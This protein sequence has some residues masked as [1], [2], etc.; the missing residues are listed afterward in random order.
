MSSSEKH[1]EDIAEI[2]Q[3][4]ERS[5]RF[6]SLSGWSGVSAGVFAL[7][8]VF[9]VPLMIRSTS[10]QMLEITLVAGAL[11]VLFLALASAL[12]FSFR[13]ARKQGTKLWSPVTRS[14]LVNMAIPLLTGGIYSAI[15]L[16]QDQGHLLAGIT[17]IFYGLA[18]VNAGR[19]TN[20]EAVILGILE[21]TLGIAATIW[22]SKGLWF[23]GAGF[24]LLHIIYGITLHYKYDRL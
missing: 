17:L 2:R 5:S 18:L 14:L 8:G 4:M 21:I 11:I 13:K 15:L 1:L 19:F 3:M 16:L 10:S 6:I 23:W 12:F 7:I 22:Q 24:G 9:T 20:K